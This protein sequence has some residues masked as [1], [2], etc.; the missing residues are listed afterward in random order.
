ML[1]NPTIF[2]RNEDGSFSL[3]DKLEK[4]KET[5]KNADGT[6][7]INCF[8]EDVLPHLEIIQSRLLDVGSAIATPLT[9]EKTKDRRVRGR[10]TG[11]D[12]LFMSRRYEIRGFFTPSE[13]DMPKVREESTTDGGKRRRGEIGRDV[14]EQVVG[15]FVRGGE[16]GESSGRRGRRVL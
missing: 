14:L 10:V 16:S 12:E 11:V 13:G 9:S 2:I 4:K 1:N 6:S 7:D 5:K 3:A 15:L 8:D